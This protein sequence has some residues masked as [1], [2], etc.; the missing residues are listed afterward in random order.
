MIRC[1][2]EV[3]ARTQLFR[4]LTT[5]DRVLSFFF[6]F[7]SFLLSFFWGPPLYIA[8]FAWAKH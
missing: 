2:K 7:P 8:S 1:W 3:L 6:I 4:L 5:H